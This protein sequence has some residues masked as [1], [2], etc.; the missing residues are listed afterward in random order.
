LVVASQVQ[1]LVKGVARWF[2][3]LKPIVP[4]PVRRAVSAQLY[5]WAMPNLPDR[6]YLVSVIIPFIYS[7]R[8]S[9]VLFVG[10]RSYT[11]HYPRLFA[12]RGIEVWTIDVD[13]AAARWGAR[14]R[15]I[16]G[17][18]SALDTV[19]DL[20]QVDC[21]VFNGILGFGIDDAQGARR[22]FLGF[23]RVLREGSLLVIGWDTDK[24]TDPRDFHELTCN[25]EDVR[26]P[27]VPPRQVFEDS[28]HVYDLLVRR[29][30]A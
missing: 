16:T 29:P 23:A 5:L 24:T 21:I 4:W 20:P 13:P 17:D 3:R 12:R 9:R 22:S 8:P 30:E 2:P 6:R 10:C 26:D 19:A 1:G 27:A 11:A 15:H 14:G 25:F 28:T 18:A 7:R